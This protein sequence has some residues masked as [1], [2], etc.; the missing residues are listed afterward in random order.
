MKYNSIAV[1]GPT[2]VGKTYLA[3]KLA[4][5]FNGEIISVDSRQVYRG[6]DIGTGKDLED[7]I[8]E[9]HHIPYHLIDI[10]N[11]DDEF[12]LFQ[13]MVS[14]N[15]AFD[16][17]NNKNKNPF[18]VGG[19]GLFLHSLFK[20]YKLNRAEFNEKKISE[21]SSLTIEELRKRLIN[22]SGKPLHNTTDLIEKKR[23][24]KAILI[25][26]SSNADIIEPRK[27]DP[28]IFCLLPDRKI[29]HARI[30]KRLD[31]RLKNGM[32]D[33]VEA[34][35]NSGVSTK[36][37]DLFGL[38]YRYISLY[39]TG[40]INYNDMKQKLSSAIKRFAKKQI[41]WIRKFEK[42]GIKMIYFENPDFDRA[43]EIIEKQ[44]IN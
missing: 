38:E 43:A 28:L 1:I 7:Y 22:S 23:I 30:K 25:S 34:L 4:N 32:I 13:F 9:N 37:L 24:I 11:P 42:E 26:E 29:I 31:E 35:I 3:T 14:F 40:E 19:T 39:L 17:I 2:A 5:K 21:L 8:V 12:N 18:I 6:M 15:A 44:F 16:I 10:I 20:G 33:E 41:T 36:R 27:I